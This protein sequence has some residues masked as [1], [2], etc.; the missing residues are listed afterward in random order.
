M[1]QVGLHV[2]MCYVVCV[3]V[4]YGLHG[5]CACHGRCI[6][7]TCYLCFTLFAKFLHGGYKTCYMGIVWCG[8]MLHVVQAWYMGY[9]LQILHVL[10]AEIST[11]CSSVAKICHTGVTCHVT[12]LYGVYM[13]CNNAIQG[14]H[15]AWQCHTGFTCCVTMLYKVCILCNNF[16]QGLHAA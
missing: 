12:M 11:W 2:C 1:L 6:H 16:I 3:I 13:L 15:T 10:V 7:V 9:L 8:N 4:A 14:L 5:V